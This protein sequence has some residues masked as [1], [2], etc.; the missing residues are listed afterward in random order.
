MIT[1]VKP[2]ERAILPEGHGDNFG[3][4]EYGHEWLADIPLESE[5]L[6]GRKI[7]YLEPNY[8]ADL[9]R[10]GIGYEASTAEQEVIYSCP[11]GDNYYYWIMPVGIILSGSH[12]YLY[13]ATANPVPRHRLLEIG[14]KCGTDFSLRECMENKI[15]TAEMGHG[16]T[17]STLPSDGMGRRRF[18][19]MQLSNG[20]AILVITWV[21]FNK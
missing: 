2:S 5:E 14:E 1:I 13:A 9:L 16:F 18:A 12:E 15:M 4:I 3:S 11:W 17:T 20:D 10:L 7:L 8:W 19:L 6:L 21:W